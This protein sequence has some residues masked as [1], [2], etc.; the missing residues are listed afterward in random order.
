MKIAVA[1]GKGGTGKT[2][3]STNLFYAVKEIAG[4]T[5]D[6]LDCDVEE[7]NSGIFL[8][9][10]PVN[11]KEV[12]TKI[13]VI[14]PGKCTF[15]GRCVHFC[16]AHA[17]LMVKSIGHIA[18]MEDL[19]TSCG[20][21]V[22]A[23][24]DGAITEKDKSLGKVREF[25]IGDSRFLEG[26]INIGTAFA[27]PVI[28]KVK[29]GIKDENLTIIDSPPGTSCPVIETVSDV[30]YVVL[31]TEPS[32]FGLHDLKLMVETLRQT[33]NRFGVVIN[34]AGFDFPDIYNYLK[35]EKIEL[36]LE[37]P[38]DRKSAEN[39]AHGKLLIDD[40]EKL[41]RDLQDMYRKIRKITEE[42]KG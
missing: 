4:E 11:E 25:S 30:D 41:K 16:E 18:V 39:Y 9:G 27:T 31:V 8:K 22:Y 42:D 19:C 34:R 7:P 10:T 3:V 40:N 28:K 38:F 26:E 23:C 37:I 13:P 17:I 6:F 12:L 36:L 1:S 14:D 21:C 15:C 24:N 32:P 2:T 5:V 35:E 20:A 29:A 33:G